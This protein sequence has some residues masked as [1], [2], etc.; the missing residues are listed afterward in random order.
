MEDQL[1]LEEEILSLL[2]TVRYVFLYFYYIFLYF[3]YNQRSRERNLENWLNYFIFKLWTMVPKAV[4]QAFN[5]QETARAEG[6]KLGS[7]KWLWRITGDSEPLGAW[8]EGRGWDR[9]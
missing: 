5:C 3:Y 7:C 8:S 1:S 6:E 4:I 2:T 9:R